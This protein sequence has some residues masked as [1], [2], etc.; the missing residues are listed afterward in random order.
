VFYLPGEAL[1]LFVMFSSDAQQEDNYRIRADWAIGLPKVTALFGHRR[2]QTFPARLIVN[3]KG[4]T[5]SRVLSEVLK[6]YAEIL[7][8]DAKDEDGYCVCFKLDGGPL[9]SISQC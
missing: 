8:P 6:Q 9:Q 4:G 1:P 2:E 3:E 5:D 7:Y